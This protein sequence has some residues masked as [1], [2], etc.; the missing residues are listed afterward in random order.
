LVIR[1][2]SDVTSSRYAGNAITYDNDV[3]QTLQIQNGQS[4][5]LSADD[6]STQEKNLYFTRT[7]RLLRDSRE[8]AMR[9]SPYGQDIT[10]TI[11]EQK[12]SAKLE[13]VKI[14]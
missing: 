6:K 1:P 12:N 13:S 14:T 2:F 11:R 9:V 3:F 10:G 8:L 4:T 7:S 5:G